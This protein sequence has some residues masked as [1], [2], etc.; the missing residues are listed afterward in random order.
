MESA[1]EG[2]LLR[3]AVLG[4]GVNLLQLRFPEEIAAI[5]TSLLIESG[6][7]VHPDEVLGPL[8][9]RIEDWYRVAIES[10]DRV[11]SRWTEVSSYSNGASVRLVTGNCVFEGI[12]R[13]L[14][15]TGALRIETGDGRRQSVTAG[16]VSLRKMGENGPGVT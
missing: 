9:V 5:A 14:S 16:E 1:S 7:V 10:P 4:I 11:L 6:V 2:E 8:L 12:T 13:G 15:S 3:Y